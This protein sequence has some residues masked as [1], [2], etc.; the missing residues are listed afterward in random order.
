MVKD[1]IVAGLIKDL[2]SRLSAMSEEFNA[3]AERLLDARAEDDDGVIST[4]MLLARARE[5]L[6]HSKLRRQFLPAE[7]FH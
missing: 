3:N 1:E 7:L 2:G 6:A 4:P 5:I